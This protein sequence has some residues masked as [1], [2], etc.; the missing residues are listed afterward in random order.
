MPCTGQQQPASGLTMPQ[1]QGT[2]FGGVSQPPQSQPQGAGFGQSFNFSGQ[3]PSLAG[4]SGLGLSGAST[5][6][7]PSSGGLSFGAPSSQGVGLGGATQA[8]ATQSA[9]NSQ[10]FQFNPNAGINF[11][12]GGGGGPAAPLGGG[13]FTAGKDS[14]SSNTS[15]RIIKKARRRK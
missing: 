13:V 12:F 11:N 7:P 10:G 2:I 15:Q 9:A 5:N 3:A 8:S 6:F 14:G 1:S 4:G